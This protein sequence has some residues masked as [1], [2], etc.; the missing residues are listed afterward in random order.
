MLEICCGERPFT[1]SDYLANDEFLEQGKI[2]GAY[3]EVRC[4]LRQTL[5]CIQLDVIA[6]VVSVLHNKI[7]WTYCLASAGKHSSASQDLG[8]RLGLSDVCD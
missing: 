4:P 3:H 8:G 2:A 1:K 5:L 7:R 6:E